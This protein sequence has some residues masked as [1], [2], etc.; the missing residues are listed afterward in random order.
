MK[1]CSQLYT[2]P[3]CPCPSLTLFLPSTLHQL[4][5][6]LSN[7]SVATVGTEE[8]ESS[9]L[10]VGGAGVG[11]SVG[12]AG[13]VGDNV[14]G[15]ELLDLL[16][17][18]GGAVEI[19]QRHEVERQTN[20]V[21]G[22]HRGTRDGVGGGLGADPGGQDLLTGG[23]DVDDL[24]EVGE[25]SAGVVLADG[26]D[27]DGIGGRGRAGLAGIGVLVTG[28]DNG[29]DTLLEGALDGVVEGLGEGTTQ[30]HVDGGLVG[31]LLL[32]NV[33]DGPV[34]AVQDDGGAGGLALEDP[35]GNELSLLGNAEGLSTDGTGDVGTVAH[36][37][38]IRAASGV[39]ALGGAALE[40][41]V[42]NV[43][44]GI[45]DVAEGL[46]AGLVIVDVVGALVTLVGDAA[47]TPR[48]IL[49][50]LDGI[51]V[52]DLVLFDRSNLEKES[53]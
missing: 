2:W 40:L 45:N 13:D 9:D 14:G 39:V 30:G 11:E 34:E 1:Q 41:L 32:D 5:S 38:L 21:G 47:Q 36:S 33:V 6:P 48:S 12:A 46:G 28:G 44:T 4:S 15:S 50:G 19:L 37:V 3:L 18:G 7:F 10:L 52:P 49:L 42:L 43:D 25:V 16:G 51:K 29:E 22:G 53:C 17:H 27:G 31:A 20:N 23:E 24:A 35:H 8:K 26:G